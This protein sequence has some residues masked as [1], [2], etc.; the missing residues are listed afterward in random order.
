MPKRYTPPQIAKAYGV[1]TGKIL[2]LIKNGE[3]EAIDLGI[4][5]FGLPRYSISE[6]AI[7]ALRPDGQLFQSHR[8]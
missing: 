1:N 2:S 4:T 8:N 3:L 7:A 6:E 5:R